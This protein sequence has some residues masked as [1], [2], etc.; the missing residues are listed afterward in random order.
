MLDSYS[1]A[2]EAIRRHPGFKE[3]VR[4]RGR[5]SLT[6]LAL[7]LGTY[8]VLITLVAFAPGLL[9]QPLVEGSKIT[10]GV[11]FAVFVIVFGIVMTGVYVRRANSELDELSDRVVMEAVK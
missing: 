6:L 4:R 1:R 3:L 8:F 7:M 9:M 10:V 11:F 5:L 2:V